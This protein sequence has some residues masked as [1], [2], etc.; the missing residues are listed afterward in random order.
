[1]SL[2]FLP[3]QFFVEDH[4]LR[5]LFLGG[6]E[7]EGRI[8]AFGT[9]GTV[10][11]PRTGSMAITCLMD[12]LHCPAEREKYICERFVSVRLY[13]CSDICSVTYYSLG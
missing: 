6:E 9:L 7:G 2:P 4:S 12:T 11:V 3:N 5:L 10:F 1:M 8:S 13:L